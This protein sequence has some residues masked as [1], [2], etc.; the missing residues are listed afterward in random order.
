MLSPLSAIATAIASGVR[1]AQVPGWRSAASD[2]GGSS[3]S[4]IGLRSIVTPKGSCD[5]PRRQ[6]P[7]RSMGG[8]SDRS[9]LPF[10]VER[11]VVE[12]AED[13][14]QAPFLEDGQAVDAAIQHQAGCL[15]ERRV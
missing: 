8:P 1:A 2:M 5:D 10:L 12:G 14:D 15:D 7:S 4:G 6:P 9:G 3:R 13:A 11:H